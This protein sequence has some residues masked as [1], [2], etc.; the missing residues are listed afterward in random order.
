MGERDELLRGFDDARALLSAAVEGLADDDFGRPVGEGRWTVE[1][2]INHVAAWDQAA[3][4]AVRALVAGA[5][6]AMRPVED[7]DAWNEGAVAPHRGRR[8]P[9]TL[10]ALHAARDAFRAV[11]D[12]APAELWAVEPRTGANGEARNL[13]GIVR[14]WAGHDAAHAAELRAVRDH[15]AEPRA[16]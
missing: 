9:E 4:A 10:A 5:P 1:D 15:G 3:T 13:P 14:A 2:V 12:A 16:S 7:V 11:V 6:P 8:P